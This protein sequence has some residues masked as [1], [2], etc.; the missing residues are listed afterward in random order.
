M[1]VEPK[2]AAAELR[3]KYQRERYAIR[4][5]RATQ[6]DPVEGNAPDALTEAYRAYRRRYYAQDP[7]KQKAAQQRYREK[8]AAEA[9]SLR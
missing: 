7:T 3:R 9:E 6:Q 8:K 1:P 2:E 5:Q 4:K